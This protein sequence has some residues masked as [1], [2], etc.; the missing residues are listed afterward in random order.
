ML[1]QLVADYGAGDLA[2]AEVVGA[3]YSLMPSGTTVQ[4]T[5]VP[6]FD[7]VS[8][9]F[10]V[11]Q[12][13]RAELSARR[14]V[15]ANC[16]PRED[17]NEAR[18]NNEGEGLLYALLSNGQEV[19]AVNSGYSLS[20]LRDDIESLHV[21]NVSRGGSQFRSRDTFPAI[22]AAIANDDKSALL[23]RIDP[24]VVIAESPISCVGYIDSFGN[25]KTTIRDGDVVLDTLKPGARVKVE[26][27]GIRRTVTVASGS[28]HV[29]EGDMAF[30]PGSSGYER[31]FWELFQRGGSAWHTFGCPRAGA[32]IRLVS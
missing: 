21:L 31:R 23:G 27:N 4:V 9:G 30:A 20:F 16:A 5:S 11:A 1:V 18:E 19:V 26:I 8:T 14:M 10:A 12:L 7:T 17:R 6:S 22:V 29:S 15:F 24:K 32:P 28:F 3:L 2:F 13:A 25:M